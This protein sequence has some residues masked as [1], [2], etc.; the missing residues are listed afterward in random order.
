MTAPVEIPLWGTLK[1]TE[2]SKEDLLEVWQKILTRTALR[3]ETDHKVTDVRPCDG[4]FV[5][6]TATAEYRARNV[7]LALGRRGT[8]RKLG[9]PGEDLSKVMYRL[10]DADGYRENDLLVVG[11]G[12]SA[13]EAAVGLALHNTNRVTLSYRKGEFTRIKERNRQKIEEYMRRKRVSILFNSEVEEIL[14]DSVRIRTSGSPLL[15]PNDNVFIF[16]GGDMP[17]ELLRRA[18]IRFQNQAV[19]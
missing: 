2:V 17:F 19:E 10:I 1:L 13:I 6:V 14:P 12:D 9:V 3:V 11:G 4:G 15:L 8:P 7:V 5:L 16:A 18:G